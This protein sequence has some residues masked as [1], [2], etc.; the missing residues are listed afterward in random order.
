MGHR[1]AAVHPG[2]MNEWL[3]TANS[4]CSCNTRKS[5]SALHKD[6]GHMKYITTVPH[7]RQQ[8]LKVP[9]HA[10]HLQP[11]PHYRCCCCNCTPLPVIYKRYPTMLLRRN[12]PASTIASAASSSSS[13][14]TQTVARRALSSSSRSSSC[15]TRTLLASTRHTTSRIPSPQTSRT[16]STFSTF[17]LPAL[18]NEP[19]VCALS[20]IDPG[21][22]L[23]DVV[24]TLR[25]RHGRTPEA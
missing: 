4:D 8:T 16:M 17:K 19:N 20:P 3:P 7:I 21:F 18:E 2:Y 22:L 13:R 11:T 15:C 6:G 25:Q 14:A 9:R 5:T 12:V 10:R 24:A 1:D 23:I